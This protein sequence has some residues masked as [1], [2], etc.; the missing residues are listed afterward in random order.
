MKQNKGFVS[1]IFLIVFVLLVSI[2]SYFFTRKVK[3]DFPINVKNLDSALNGGDPTADWENYSNKNFGFEFK[4]P[5][6]D[7]LNK[8]VVI[9]GDSY[10]FLGYPE[11][12]GFFTIYVTKNDKIENH[13]NTFTSDIVESKRDINLNG[14]SGFEVLLKDGA[15]DGFYRSP[16]YVY[17][18]NK[19][20]VYEVYY[21]YPNHKNEL[22]DR[23]LST[24]KFF[25]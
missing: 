14:H 8:V 13:L 11:S 22:C 21:D 2:V 20:N 18:Q 15:Q 24:L 5:K 7:E 23:I 6:T 1:I 16:K 4:Y 10:V 9:E 12:E 3:V 17:L 19:Q 25:D